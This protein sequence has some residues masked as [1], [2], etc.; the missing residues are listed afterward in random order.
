MRKPF[1][2]TITLEP[3]GERLT[4]FCCLELSLWGY[5]EGLEYTLHYGL[6]NIQH[7]LA[8]VLTRGLDLELLRAPQAFWDRAQEQ[9]GSD[10][11]HAYL[12]VAVPWPDPKILEPPDVETR[13]FCYVPPGVYCQA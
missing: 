1:L 8:E 13:V 6:K 4:K 9:A 3:Y 10:Q 12:H 11:I 7:R 2:A 5:G